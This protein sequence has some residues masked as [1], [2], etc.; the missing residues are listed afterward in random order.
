MSHRGE[1]LISSK[2][3]TMNDNDLLQL[4][5]NCADNIQRQTPLARDARKILTSINEI[6]QGRL[7]NSRVGLYKADTPEIGILGTVGYH[8]GKSGEKPVK[9]QQMLDFVISEVLPFVG[10]L[11][12]MHEWGLP[13]SPDRYRKLHRVLTVFRSGALSDDRLSEAV[14]D[15]TDD[16]D[17]L[18]RTWHAKCRQSL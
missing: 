2:L 18:E 13:L 3:G 9:R 6:W 4:F 10:S 15:W 1:T 16:L 12:Y 8:V 17:Y 14:S 7:A 11:A 5:R